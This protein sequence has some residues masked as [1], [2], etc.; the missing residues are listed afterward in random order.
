MHTSKKYLMLV[1]LFIFIFVTVI[2]VSGFISRSSGSEGIFTASAT[3]EPIL[4]DEIL[5]RYFSYVENGQFEQMYN[6][7]TNVSHEHSGREDFIERNRNIYEGIGARNIIVTIN[8]MYDVPERPGRKMV[9][10]TLRMDTVAGEILYDAYAIFELSTEGTYKLQWTSN[11]IFPQLGDD[12]RVRV[13]ILP[14]QRGNIFDR[15]GVILAGPGT[16]SA[17]GFIPG[18]MRREEIPAPTIVIGNV[19]DDSEAEIPETPPT[20]I[21]NE[22][23]IARVAELLEMTPEGVLRRLNAS[24]IRDDIFLQLRI[25]PRDAQA[26]IDELLTVQG[27]MIS[28]AHVRYYPLGQSAAHLV[29]YVQNIN[30]E[31]LESRR[32]DGYHMNSVI[33]RA[34]LERIY[35]DRLRARDGR[36]IF[37]IDSQGNRTTTLA[38]LLPV[39]GSDIRLTIDADIQR[40]LFDSFAEDKSASVA[41]N[42]LT[43]EVLALVSTPSYD[44]NDFVRG[45]TTSVWTALTE[46]EN[47]PF[48]NRFSAT[49]SPG[50]TMKAMTAAIG[51]DAGI[52]YPNEDFGR[53]GLRWQQDESWGRF[54]VTTVRTYDGPANL[55]NAM[56]WSDNIYFAKAALRIGADLFTRELQ[57]FGFA[58]TI[59]FEYGLA[60]SSI[61][62]TGGIT[63]E[64]QLA[65]S[66]YGQGEILMNP[67]HLAALY[68]AFVNDGNIL[69]PWLIYDRPYTPLLWV[70]E[71]FSPET[72]RYVLDSLIFS[73]DYGTGRGA[74]VSGVTLA[75]KTGTAEIKLT[76]DDDTGTEIGWFVLLTADEDVENPLLV[77]SMVE[78][79]QGRGGSGYVIPRVATLFH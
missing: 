22:D 54:F 68:A 3:S 66:G 28:T 48:F 16:A 39:N 59:P 19:Y 72:A 47:L 74:R 37:I 10:Y 34:G 73:V 30:A 71:A 78:D 15:N 38:R 56:A 14:A 1:C 52:F 2:L 55:N 79:V 21:Y 46:D 77:V 11:M 29:G 64:I 6:L 63:S 23:D 43:G 75:G 4:P 76:Q 31:E 17:V 27:I 13:S 33:G 50:S 8:D 45:M 12:D 24:Y 26:L 5:L 35:E 9:A 58:N 41:T 42:P 69:E 53:S 36:E 40:Q 65:D 32:H 20:Y 60:S 62:R 18:R 49:F 51:I 57:N 7:L 44:P 25:I 61:S 67:V 70:P